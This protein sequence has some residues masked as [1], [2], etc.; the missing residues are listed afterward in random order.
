MRI[1]PNPSSDKIY[2]EIP[3][4]QRAEIQVYDNLG[5]RIFIPIQNN[6]TQYELDI[7]ETPIGLYT[8]RIQ[9]NGKQSFVGKFIK[10]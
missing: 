10:E 4:L 6:G 3:N 8:I 2:F 7:N 5:K 9:S 1:Y